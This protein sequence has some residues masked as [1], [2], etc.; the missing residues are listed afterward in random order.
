MSNEDDNHESIISENDMENSP[1]IAK[2]SLGTWDGVFL[3]CVQNIFGVVL[4]L[5]LPWVVV[6][7]ELNLYLI[8]SFKKANY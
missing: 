6:T 8:N 4:F 1:E 2:A 3:S 7:I 5:L